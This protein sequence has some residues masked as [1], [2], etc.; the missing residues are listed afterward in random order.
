MRRFTFLLFAIVLTTN[1]TISQTKIENSEINSS[2]FITASDNV[3]LYAK[4]SGNGP[5]CIFVH[6]G[7]GAWSKSFEDMKGNNLEK[8]LNMVYFD[9]RGCGRSDASI[10]KNYSLD[11]MTDDI[12]DIRRS[13]GVEKIYLLSHSFGGI[14]AANYAKKHPDHLYGLI[15]ANSTLNI[16]YSFESQ[17]KSINKLI[18]TNFKATNKDTFL[19]TFITARNAL[20]K[21]GLSYKMLSD[22][23]KTI[24]MIDS[25]DNSYKRTQDFA[26]H[27]G[28]F[29]IYSEDFTKETKNINIPVLI[30]TGK[31]D[32]AIGPDHYKSFQ[33][34]TQ[35]V[36]KINGGHVLYY[37]Q[38][39]AFIKA[40]FSFIQ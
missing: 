24:N 32:Y 14:I 19:S 26:K 38:N 8:K 39:D 18:S 3:K 28:D 2:S 35:K 36:V 37:E 4:V 1:S 31:K 16:N 12:E 5:V 30:I 22:T 6:G 17:I 23:K 20:S 15:L 27:F 29:K 7:P 9:Q 10:D 13:L 21:K 40:I 33:F 25:I 34:P 11:R